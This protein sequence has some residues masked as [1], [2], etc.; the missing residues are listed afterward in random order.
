MSDRVWLITGASRG[1]GADVARAVLAAG[2]KLVATAR[3]SAAL[4]H[5]GVSDNLLTVSLDVTDEKQAADAVAALVVDIVRAAAVGIGDEG[6]AV[7]RIVA[8][9]RGLALGIG[10]ADEI[11]RVVIGALCDA[12]VG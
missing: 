6:G 8:V 9:A 2:D 3:R 7:Q 4:E 5:L 1:I 12:A 10:A 11:A